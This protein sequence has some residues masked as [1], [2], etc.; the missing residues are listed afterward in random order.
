MLMA[1]EMGEEHDGS[2]PGVGACHLLPLWGLISF[3]F[4]FSL[5]FAFST[6]A[7]AFGSCFLGWGIWLGHHKEQNPS[8]VFSSLG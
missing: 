5:L 2:L 1:H 8:L 7:W 6:A 3:F 4:A